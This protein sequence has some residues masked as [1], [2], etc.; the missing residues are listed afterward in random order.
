VHERTNNRDQRRALHPRLAERGLLRHQQRRHLFM[1][2][3]LGATVSAR[4]PPVRVRPATTVAAA[5][6]ATAALTSAAVAFTAA[7]LTS[8]TVA[9]TA[10]AITSATVAVTAAAIATAAFSAGADSTCSHS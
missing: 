2:R 4:V 7:A 10:A 8:T 1:Q 9:F 5:A 6:L 3:C